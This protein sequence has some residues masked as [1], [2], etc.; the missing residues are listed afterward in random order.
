MKRATSSYKSASRALRYVLWAAA[1]MLVACDNSVNFNPTAPEWPPI[2]PLGERSLQITGSLTAERGS[3]LEATILYD[4]VE[5][6]GA[7]TVCSEPSGCAT[8]TLAAETQSSSGRH[9]ISFQVLD[10][11]A[12]AVDYLGQGEVLVTREGLQLDGV[13]IQLGPEQATLRRGDSVTFEVWF[14]D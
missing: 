8:Q 4:G 10:Q 5:L 11:S 7:R 3:C 2:T 12:T 1:M 13:R 9:M 6:A 14:T